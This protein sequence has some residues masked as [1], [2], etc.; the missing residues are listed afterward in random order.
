MPPRGQKS[1]GNVL[2]LLA[3]RQVLL[4][5]ASTMFLFMG[6]FALFTYLRPYLESAGGFTIEAISL[7]LLL[8]GLAGVLGTALAAWAL[9]GS[10]VLS[11]GPE[12]AEGRA[13]RL[14]AEGVSLAL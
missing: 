2:R 12:P 4:G 5:M 13:K 6:Q 14:V 11:R 7:V 1:I 10:I 3:R 8:M 9:D